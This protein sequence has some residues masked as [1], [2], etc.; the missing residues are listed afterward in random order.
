MLFYLAKGGNSTENGAEK[1]KIYTCYSEFPTLD[2]LIRKIKER[3]FQNYFCHSLPY[4]L[5]N[6]GPSDSMQ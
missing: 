6:P 5:Y 2:F 4:F 1:F 3:E